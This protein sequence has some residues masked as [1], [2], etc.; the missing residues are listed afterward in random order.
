LEQV[1][2]W[3]KQFGQNSC[4]WGDEPSIATNIALSI[5]KEKQIKSILIPGVGYGRNSKVFTSTGFDVTGVEISSTACRL[6]QKYDPSLKLLNSSIFEIQLPEEEYDA[7]F[8]FDVLHLFLK[9]DR[10]KFIRKCEKLVKPGGF[11]FFT[12]LSEH[13]DYFRNGAEVEA[14]TFEVK[15]GKLIHFFSKLDLENSF[16][17]FNKLQEGE[18]LDSVSHAQHGQKEYRIRYICVQKQSVIGT[19]DT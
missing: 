5:F 19:I 11:L 17:Q 1:K 9:G 4:I 12:V 3:D 8:C 2:Y 6:A 10:D 13:D 16:A 14:N 7:V 18:I 15:P